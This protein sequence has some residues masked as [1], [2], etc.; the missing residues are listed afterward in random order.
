MNTTFFIAYIYY[1]YLR[2]FGSYVC[3]DEIGYFLDAQASQ[4]EMIVRNS[5]TVKPKPNHKDLPYLLDLT[6]QQHQQQQ[7]QQQGLGIRD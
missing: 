2:V 6:D 7:Q 1:L 5:M 4:D 3:H